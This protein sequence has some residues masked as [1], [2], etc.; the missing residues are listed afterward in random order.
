MGGAVFSFFWLL[1]ENKPKKKIPKPKTKNKNKTKPQK[2]KDN[3]TQKQKQKN[4]TKIKVKQKEKYKICLKQT[5]NNITIPCGPAISV[6][7]ILVNHSQ[8]TSSRGPPRPQEGHE[9]SCR[10]Y[11]SSGS[12]LAQPLHVCAHKVH[13]C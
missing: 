11:G 1:K 6:I 8:L 12:D 10:H 5:K 3:N 9:A 7:A 13:S 2:S 4:K